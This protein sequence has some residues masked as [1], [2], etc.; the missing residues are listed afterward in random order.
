MASCRLL[1]NL[2]A[3]H[4]LIGNFVKISESTAHPHLNTNLVVDFRNHFFI[5]LKL[6]LEVVDLK[7]KS[8]LITAS[9]SMIFSA[10]AK[11]QICFAYWAV[12]AWTS[13]STVER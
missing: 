4:Q 3:N 8:H 2:T 13:C 11:L 12:C 1:R 5:L 10:H 7:P 6:Q 9:C